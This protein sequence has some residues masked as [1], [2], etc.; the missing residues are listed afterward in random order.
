M[1]NYIYLIGVLCFLPLTFHILFK[2][3]FQNLFKANNIWEIKV[4]YLLL[5]LSFAHI[6]ASLVERFYL[7]SINI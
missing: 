4:A 6:L 1:E 3:K 7:L 5:S 2:L